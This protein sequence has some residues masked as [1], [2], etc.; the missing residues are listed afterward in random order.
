MSKSSKEVGIVKE[1]R[2]Y[3]VKSMAGECLEE[4]RV[5]WHGLAGDRRFAFLKVGNSTGL[6]FLSAR[7][8]PRLI[9]YRAYFADGEDLEQS[10]ILVE[11]PSGEVLDL[12]SPAL[13]CELSQ[14]YRRSELSLLQLWRGAYDSMDISLITTSSIKAVSER[15]GL[16]LEPVRFRPNILV[17]SLDQ[18]TY[19]E[20]RWVGE[21]LVFGDRNNSARIRG[22]R[23]DVR[24]MIVNL[25]PETARQ[26]PVVMKEIVANRR[27]LLGIY[28]TTE[29]PGTICVGDVVHLVTA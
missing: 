20:D 29:R 6:P 11:T 18:R 27:N 3:P 17:E 26:D 8:V 23:K 13:L 24:C 9:L 7:D 16:P 12:T 2:R 15:V 22:N 28:G 5:G 19:P 14:A 21:L 4:T 10:S 1:I 25:N